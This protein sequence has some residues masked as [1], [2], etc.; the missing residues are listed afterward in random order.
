MSYL[1]LE[2]TMNDPMVSHEGQRLQHLTS[3]SANKGC[4]EP[5]EVVRL[6]QF[7]KVDA[8]QLHRNAQVATK[9]EVLRHLDDVMLFVLIL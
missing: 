2:I 7:I 8:Q 4:R 1:R 3:E 6:D 5:D 9:I